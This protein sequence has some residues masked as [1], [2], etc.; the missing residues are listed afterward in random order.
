MKRSERVV[1]RLSSAGVRGTILS[2]LMVLAGLSTGAAQ[3]VCIT[4][5]ISSAD[6]LSND[7]VI[8]LAVDGRGYVW[9]ATEAG[10]NRIA[11]KT[12][13]SSMQ[14][15]NPLSAGQ[16]KGRI[17]AMRWHEA[18]GN[19]L[20][21]TERA[22]SVYS[23]KDGTLRH[24]DSSDGLVP[25]SINDIASAADGGVWLVYGNGQIQHLDCTTMEA[26]TLPMAEPHENR[27]AWDDGQGRLYIG[28]SQ[29]GMTIVE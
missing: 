20:I 10:V 4:R 1:S 24:L 6:G 5:H 11:G 29:H 27:C 25:S 15:G 8:S 7:F 9:V 21:G 16:L 12:V 28:H 23:E 2:L 17:T 13:V 3:E 14:P 19:M 18:S 26:V 22:L